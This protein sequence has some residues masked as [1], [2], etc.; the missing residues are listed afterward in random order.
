MPICDWRLQI[1]MSLTSADS[2]GHVLLCFQ[3]VA[4]RGQTALQVPRSLRLLLQDAAQLLQVGVDGAARLVHLHADVLLSTMTFEDADRKLHISADMRQAE[5][6]CKQC[7]ELR[8]WACRCML[9]GKNI[10]K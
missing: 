7:E 5:S 6:F 9:M 4:E 2:L 3:L 10:L 8:D 1:A